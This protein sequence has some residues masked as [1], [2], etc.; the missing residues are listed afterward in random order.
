MC[1]TINENPLRVED[2]PFKQ[3]YQPDASLRNGH[4]E[5]RGGMWALRRLESQI[6]S[7]H[8]VVASM[9]L[10]CT[11]IWHLSMQ[12]MDRAQ[13]SSTL[14]SNDHSRICPHLPGTAQE[15]ELRNRNCHP[16]LISIVPRCK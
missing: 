14:S 8:W 6:T 5:A 1:S 9:G 3:H 2:Q 15:R 11:L 12:A 7:K 16:F 4:G 13:G 10:L